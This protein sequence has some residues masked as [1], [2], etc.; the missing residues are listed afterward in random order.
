MSVLDRFVVASLPL[1]PRF[2]VRKVADPYIAGETLDDAMRVVRELNQKGFMATVDVLGEFVAERERAEASA[3]EYLVLLDRLAR[4]KLDGNV[5]VKL[6]ALGM[7][8]SPQFVRDNLR[9]V[10]E[11]AHKNGIF[12]RIDM[13]NSPYTTETLKIYD[14]FRKEFNVGTVLQAYM[15][16][17][18]DDVKNLVAGGK[19]NFRLCKGI[20]VEPEDI[21]FK[22]REEVRD[23][24]T[25][26]LDQMF[27]AGVYVGIATHDEVLVKRAEKLI[28]KHKLGREQYEFQ[29][30]LGVLPNLRDS[31]LARGHRLRV[32]VPYGE[33][34]Y[35]Y[36]TR[37]L[38]E[39]PKMAGYVFKAMFGF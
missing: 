5:S 3:A 36:S 17:S 38:K 27:A 4:E 22:D 28:A 25:A 35:G 21:A 31:I 16:R 11:H 24:F 26:L 39:N 7:D 6:T 29:M 2:V 19:T 13:E 32:Y 33:A 10:V 9:K 12:V 8:I 15:R 23:N 20:Y 14:E 30:L 18:S 1:I 37:R 34:W